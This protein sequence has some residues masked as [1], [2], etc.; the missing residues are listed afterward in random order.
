M[1][2]FNTKNILDYKGF[3][4]PIE[5]SDED[6]CFFGR[7]LNVKGSVSYE[8]GTLEELEKDFHEAVNDYISYRKEL[9]T[10]TV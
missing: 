7:V 1:K 3:K 8:G 10:K 2:T 4:G 6:D 9:K 5:S